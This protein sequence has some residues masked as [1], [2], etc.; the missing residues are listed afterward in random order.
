MLALCNKV[1]LGR[2]VP[3]DWHL[4]HVALIYKKGDPAECG[5]YRPI[6]LLNAA[7][8]ISAMILLKRLLRAGLLGQMAVRLQ[9]NSDSE[10]IVGP[11]M[12]FIVHVVRSIAD[13]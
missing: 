13:F 11:R 9:L 8:K 1:W 4:Q 12:H 2:S 3:E 5:N 6:C 10:G 7:Y